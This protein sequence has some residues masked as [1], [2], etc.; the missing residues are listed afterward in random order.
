MSGLDSYGYH[1]GELIEW[2]QLVPPGRDLKAIGVV[3]GLPGNGKIDVLIE[4]EG[5]S[6]HWNE[7]KPMGFKSKSFKTRQQTHNED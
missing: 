6:V 7:I 2:N 1:L 5:R 3:V 4:G